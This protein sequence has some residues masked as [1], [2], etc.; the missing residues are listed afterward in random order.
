[1]ARYKGLISITVLLVAILALMLTFP[2]NVRNAT[3]G[4]GADWMCTT[5]PKGDP[6]CV[7]KVKP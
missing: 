2:A 7:K 5:Q 1:M 6:I 3:P 4:F